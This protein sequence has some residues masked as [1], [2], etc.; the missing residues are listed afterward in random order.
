MSKKTYWKGYVDGVVDGRSADQKP[1]TLK[2]YFELTDTPTSGS[3]T[4]RIMA[5]VLAKNPGLTFDQARR[6]ARRLLDKA[7]GARV[8]RMPSPLSPEE[9][10]AQKVRF[11]AFKRARGS[12][13]DLV[14]RQSGA[15]CSDTRAADVPNPCHGEA[16]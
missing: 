1:I 12:R 6:E 8:Y 11:A 3:P 4:G 13:Q 5:K 10:A 16:L 14:S 2:Q 9:Q 15:M 7:A